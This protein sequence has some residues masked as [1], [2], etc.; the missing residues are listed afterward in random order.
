MPTNKG[1]PMT[2]RQAA[3]YLQ[4]EEKT[5][6][7]YIQKGYIPAQRIGPRRLRLDRDSVI[8]MGRRIGSG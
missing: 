2:I 6:R 4:V 7:R 8:N 3:E 5:I 1:Q